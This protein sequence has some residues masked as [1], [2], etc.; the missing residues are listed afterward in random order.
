MLKTTE[1]SDLAQRVDDNEVVGGD[2]DRNLSKSKKSKYTKSRIQMR[3][4]ATGEPIFLFPGARE[5]FNQLRQ[6]FTKALIFRYFDLEYHIWIET[7]AS[8]Y[9]IGGVLSQLTSDQ[10]T[11]NSKSI[12]TEPDF[13]QWYLVAYFSRK[14]IP[15][16]TCL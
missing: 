9:A 10:V 4:R 16:E 11:L 3:I 5:A 15:T 1:L 14:K 6:A 8:S 12:S 7:D 2:G 13:G